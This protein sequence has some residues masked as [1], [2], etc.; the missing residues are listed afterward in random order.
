MFRI[1]N[2]A[3]LAA[4]SLIVIVILFTL[5]TLNFIFILAI[6]NQA[7]LIQAHLSS[8]YKNGSKS[9]KN[10]S[11]RAAPTHPPTNSN[12]TASIHA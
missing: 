9:N 4:L 10:G 8:Q 12:L 7:R 2:D 5:L 3:S 1:S 6:E 11:S